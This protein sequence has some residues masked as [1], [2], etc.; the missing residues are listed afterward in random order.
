MLYMVV[1]VALFVLYLTEL[2]GT[3]FF[4]LCAHEASCN[5]SL[6]VYYKNL[7]FFFDDLNF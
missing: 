2:F 6:M 4:S 7:T 3:T 5:I 1:R